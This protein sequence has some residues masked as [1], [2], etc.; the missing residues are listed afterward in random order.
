LGTAKHREAGSLSASNPSSALQGAN[1]LINDCGEVKL[2]ESGSQ[3]ARELMEVEERVGPT[4]F[5]SL[6]PADFGIS[7]QI[8]ATLARRLSFIGTPYW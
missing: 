2:G 5:L 4:W 8:G 7:A 1:I 6:P 3:G